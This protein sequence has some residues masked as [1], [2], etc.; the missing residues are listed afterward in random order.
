MFSNKLVAGGLA[1][2]VLALGAGAALAAPGRATTT[3]NVRSGP[4]TSYGVVSSL[5]PGEAVDIQKCTAGWCY[6]GKAGPNGWVAEAYL[7][8]V[9]G[10]VIVPPPVVV[11]P[12]IIVRP[13]IHHRPPVHR[14]RP[15][16]K[17]PVIKPPVR[18]PV[19]KPPVKPP[20][21]KPGTPKCPIKPRH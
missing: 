11:H 13:P 9:A 10:P 12:P 6:V 4:G 17:P 16:V 14:P 5:S 19:V 20:V 3:V 21:C 15:P 7:Q 8:R 2:L 1:A 18:P